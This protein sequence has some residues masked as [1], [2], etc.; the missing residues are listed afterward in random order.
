VPRAVEQDLTGFGDALATAVGRLSW[1]LIRETAD[2]SRT[3]LSVLATLREG[4]RRVTELAALEHVAQPTMT[5]LVSRLQ[6]R[7]WVERRPDSHDGRAVSVCIT[8]AGVA[9]LDALQQTRA[10]V[11]AARLAQLP[12]EELKT[13]ELALPVLSRLI[14]VGPPR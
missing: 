9:A 6:A 8:P 1:A 3:T 11:L 10:N 2:V 14:E 7:G 5:V 13:L 12:P 4:A